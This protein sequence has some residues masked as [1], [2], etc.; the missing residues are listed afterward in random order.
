MGLY[1][2]YKAKFVT[3]AEKDQKD[4]V[5]YIP[6][7]D[8]SRAARDFW[9]ALTGGDLSINYYGSGPCVASMVLSTSMGVLMPNGKYPSR[10]L[11]LNLLVEF[12]DDRM[13]TLGWKFRESVEADTS[14]TDFRWNAP[15][16]ILNLYA[17]HGGNC[18][19]EQV[20]TETV[21][22]PIYAM[23]CA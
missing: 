12:I 23:K 4:L 14:S 11:E 13:E 10:A 19:Y 20:G 3:K 18:R 2:K 1:K 9:K 22:Q 15:G 17:Y 21:E 8:I 5:E 16:K 7:F 6:V